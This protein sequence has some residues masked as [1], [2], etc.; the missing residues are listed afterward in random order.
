MAGW[1]AGWLGGLAGRLVGWLA[2]WLAG[3][4]HPCFVRASTHQPT[5]KIEESLNIEECHIFSA[6]VEVKLDEVKEEDGGRFWEDSRGQ[7]PI[8]PWVQE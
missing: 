5:M 8:V 1:L 3:C 7:L 4:S 2:G 6:A